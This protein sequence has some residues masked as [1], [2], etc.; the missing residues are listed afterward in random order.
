[1]FQLLITAHHHGDFAYLPRL[2][3]HIRQLKR[4]IEGKVFLI[5]TGVAWSADSWVCEATEN[6]APYIVMDAMGYNFAFADGLNAE[7][8]GRL[9]M[10]VQVQLIPVGAMLQLTFEDQ[11]LQIAVNPALSEPALVGN[12]L[13][14]DRPAQGTIR[15]MIVSQ[16]TLQKNDLHEVNRKG[17]PD[18]TIAATV[19]F[20]EGEARYYFHN[21]KGKSDL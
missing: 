13:N 4:S 9:R 10:Q 14:L 12:L 16:N 19:E 17:L 20:V 2:F 7:N 11:L 18:P 5:D 15:H 1:M 3:T 8:F 21:K 6:R